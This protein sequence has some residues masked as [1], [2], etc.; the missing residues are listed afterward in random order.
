MSAVA[1]GN[2]H[3]LLIPK[4]EH[5]RNHSTDGEPS[6]ANNSSD[7]NTALDRRQKILSI[8]CILVT[9][10][11]ERLTFYGAS[12]NLVLFSKNILKLDSPWPSTISLSFLGL[13]IIILSF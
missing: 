7:N 10:L 8:L 13:F 5:D 9:E 11:C 1:E 3:S 2:E 6:T 4:E 12:A